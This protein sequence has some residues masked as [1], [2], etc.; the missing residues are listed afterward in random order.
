M[1]LIMCDL[2]E[3]GMCVSDVRIIQLLKYK[4]GDLV[5][6]MKEVECCTICAEKIKDIIANHQ[7]GGK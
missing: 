6:A 4:D 3:Q 5:P 2:C 7:K 1:R